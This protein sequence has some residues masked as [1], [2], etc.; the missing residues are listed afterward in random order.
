[1]LKHSATQGLSTHLEGLLMKAQP[2]SR[3]RPHTL[4][5]RPGKP[6]RSTEPQ[7]DTA[8]GQRGK[9]QLVGGQSLTLVAVVNPQPDAR[10]RRTE[11]TQA[12]CQRVTCRIAG[13]VMQVRSRCPGRVILAFFQPGQKRCHPYPGCDPD[14]PCT[15]LAPVIVETAIR[16]LDQHR[17]TNIQSAGQITGIVPQGLDLEG[18]T[19]IP[20][21][22]AGNRERM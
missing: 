3:A 14:L 15:G 22:C 9:R 17:L 12:R 4:A 19:S 21:I 5:Q 20:L 16:P 2:R 6:D 10:Q 7:V 1:S 13:T 18:D 8:P 11:F